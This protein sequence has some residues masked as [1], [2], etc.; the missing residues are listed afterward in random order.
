[1]FKIV[2]DSD[3]TFTKVETAVTK[4]RE[5]AITKRARW[6]ESMPS[7][8]DYRKDPGR[9]LILDHPSSGSRSPGSR[10][11][12]H[13][14]LQVE[15][16]GHF[17]D[18][19]NME[20]DEIEPVFYKVATSLMKTMSMTF[21]LEDQRRAAFKKEMTNLFPSLDAVVGEHYNSDLTLQVKINQNCV[22]TNVAYHA[23]IPSC[24]KHL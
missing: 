17:I 2:C 6:E 20:D 15:A 18:Q 8:S 21:R 12:L 11:G 7:P 22:V 9:L 24:P 3:D 23:S 1:M 10:S 4:L 5:G 16:F 19:M 13:V 14:S